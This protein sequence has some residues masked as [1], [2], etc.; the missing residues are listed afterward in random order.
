MK[1][2]YSVASLLMSAGLVAVLFL[3]IDFASGFVLGRNRFY[4]PFSLL[5][6]LVAVVVAY[7]IVELTVNRLKYSASKK[8]AI[9]AA[10][11]LI[12]LIIL[13]IFL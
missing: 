2:L 10:I 8:A 9:L 5:S 7:L 11:T 4:M 13:K 6:E 12:P 1:K 3:Y